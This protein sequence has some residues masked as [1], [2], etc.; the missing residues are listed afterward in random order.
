MVH[1]L[2][3]ALDVTVKLVPGIP[4]CLKFRR[5]HVHI[6]P[7][8]DCLFLVRDDH[9]LYIRHISFGIIQRLL[10][11]HGAGMDGYP[12]VTPKVQHVRYDAVF[13]VRGKYLQVTYCPDPVT[14]PEISR[15]I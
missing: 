11:G 10:T 1:L 13:H 2:I 5:Q 15:C 12:Q 14:D 7:T 3:L 9:C 4:V 6:V 8:S